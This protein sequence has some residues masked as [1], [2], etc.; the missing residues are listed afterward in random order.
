MTKSLDQL[1]DYLLDEIGAF[2][3][4]GASIPQLLGLVKTFYDGDQ[5]VDNSLLAQVWKW[6][7]RHPDISIGVA[8]KFNQTPLQEF[9]IDPTDPLSSWKSRS[10]KVHA[11]EELIYKSICGHSRQEAQ[12]FPLEHALLM[13]IAAS[14]A[15][16]ILQGDLGRQ[17]G[18]DKRSVPKRT[19]V[20]HTKGYIV[21][22]PVTNKGTKTS[23]LILRRYAHHLA[24]PTI[25]TPQLSVRDVLQRLGDRLLDGARIELTMLVDVLGDEGEA[26]K[27]VLSRIIRT[28][29]KTGCY[30]RVK[31]AFGPS[32]HSSDLKTFV[33]QIHPPSDEDLLSLEQGPIALH[34]SIT[35]LL[36]EERRKT[37]KQGSRAFAQWNPDRLVVN[38]LQD[39]FPSMAPGFEIDAR[40]GLM[41]PFV[42]TAIFPTAPSPSP[43]SRPNSSQTMTS[44]LPA[45]TLPPSPASHPH[46]LTKQ[47]Q[48]VDAT[49]L[50]PRPEEPQIVRGIDGLE[51]IQP[52]MRAKSPDPDPAYTPSRRNKQQKSE[53]KVRTR[54]LDSGEETR[55]Q[56][57]PR[58]FLRGTEKFWQHH[59]WQAK[60]AQVGDQN[61]PVKKLGIMHDPAGMELFESRP[62]DFDETLVQATAAGLPIPSTP[63][64]INPD[65]VRRTRAVLDRV[66]RGAYITPAGMYLGRARHRSQLLIVRSS[67]LNL[68]DWHDRTETPTF[69]FITSMAAHSSS[70][71]R[72]RPR[73]EEL[74]PKIPRSSKNAK[75]KKQETEQPK[76][77]ISPET[78][79]RRGPK[80]QVFFEPVAVAAAV[81]PH[82]PP[83]DRASEDLADYSQY[84]GTTE[85]DT[86]P[87]CPPKQPKT[88]NAS[89]RVLRTRKPAKVALFS[90][91]SM[92]GSELDRSS[93]SAL[94]TKEPTQ[95]TSFTR[96]EA[97]FGQQD[98]QQGH[99]S[100]SEQVASVIHADIQ[101][102]TAETSTA[103]MT[104]ADQ[105][106]TTSM[107]Q[108]QSSSTDTPVLSIANTVLPISFTD[109]AEQ[110]DRIPATLKDGT[111]NA[112]QS[113]NASA[114]YRSSLGLVEVSGVCGSQTVD[115]VN[116][117]RP[118]GRQGEEDPA[119]QMARSHNNFPGQSVTGEHSDMSESEKLILRTRQGR[120]GDGAICQEILFELVQLA[121]GAAPYNR[122]TLQ[123]CMVARWQAKGG[124]GYR[125]LMK[126]IKSAAARLV[127]SEKLSEH[128]FSFRGK[129][130]AIIRRSI[131]HFPNVHA[132][133]AQVT[134][135]K[136]SIM[137]ADTTD[138]VPQE[139]ATEMLPPGQFVDRKSRGREKSTSEQSPGVPRDSYDTTHREN[140]SDEDLVSA[141]SR[142]APKRRKVRHESPPNARQETPHSET[143]PASTPAQGFLTL[144]VP[145]LGT[146]PQVRDYNSRLREPVWKKSMAAASTPDGLLSQTSSHSHGVGRRSRSVCTG[147]GRSIIGTPAQPMLPVNLDDLLRLENGDQSHNDSAE[148][149]F[150]QVDIVAKWEQREAE[151]ILGENVP[152]RFFNHVSSFQAPYHSWVGR[153]FLVHFDEGARPIERE[154]VDFPSWN[155]LKAAQQP[156]AGPYK[157]AAGKSTA[158]GRRVT[159]QS[160]G[161][162][163]K[164]RW[165]VFDDYLE[166]ENAPS[167]S[168]GKKRRRTATATQYLSQDSEWEDEYGFTRERRRPRKKARPMVSSSSSRPSPRLEGKDLVFVLGVVC[169]R[170]L[171]GGI[172]QTINWSLVRRLSPDPDEKAARERWKT[173]VPKH[174][175]EIDNLVQQFQDKYVTAFDQGE[176]PAVDFQNLG[177]TDWRGIVA[178][179]EAN[180]TTSKTPEPRLAASWKELVAEL[181][182]E[183]QRA[184]DFDSVYEHGMAMNNSAKAQLYSAVIGGAS[185]SDML[186]PKAPCGPQLAAARSYVLATVLAPDLTFDAS[187]AEAKLLSLANTGEESKLLLRRAVNSLHREKIIV[188]HAS[189]IL[190]P[191]G[192]RQWKVS[193][194]FEDVM[195][196]RRLVN[197]SL[198][199][200]ATNYKT[201]V[202]DSSFASG[203]TVS[204]SK[205]GIVDD[206]IMLAIL[207][208]ISQ[209]Q[210]TIRP[211][212]DVP[213]SRYGI[214]WENV[215]YQ[216]RLIDRSKVIF[217]TML[218][219]TKT[220]RYGDPVQSSRL[221]HVP[222]GNMDQPGGPIPLWVDIHGNVLAEWWETAVAAVLGLLNL[223]PGLSAEA[224]ERMLNWTLTSND[225]D[226]ILQ[227]SKHSAVARQ[228]PGRKGWEATAW[229]WLALGNG[230]NWT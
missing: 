226:L 180:L 108:H 23:L 182:L 197:R 174:R 203:E 110:A 192:L 123:R 219:P 183:L 191:L 156:Q 76:R 202:L 216:T 114:E 228:A 164:T 96:Q 223:R 74:E 68:V 88:I 218:S 165:T 176:A 145:H 12:L 48:D 210:I 159:R 58:R 39:L 35:D 65:W 43:L 189:D 129:G 152:W 135:L 131:L 207:N 64:A 82:L 167:P 45:N 102:S 100:H 66:D 146:L 22:Q 130:G 11:S 13:Q 7:G 2:G 90:S 44:S 33:Q 86:E 41:G 151:S 31:A 175:E 51:V 138:Y 160:T 157:D 78:A 17:T 154:Y 217:T 103:N 153:W 193:N 194:I 55:P 150:Q 204:M 101:Y 222:R 119:V 169:I 95:Q 70:C 5:C 106:V 127:E 196:S 83:E 56:G 118:D 128:T 190:E 198:L 211:G 173:L 124:K 200:I 61:V 112:T 133:S 85:T 158:Q 122:T 84:M 97:S 181:D 53:K 47:I 75:R 111:P 37:L 121:R 109:R 224:C 170:N 54:I 140:C 36:N 59:F 206:G 188:R 132:T 57:R 171:V 62:H 166:V 14:R 195:E 225:I 125:P 10:P 89:K 73:V 107:G 98:K 139:W 93:S 38:Q 99:V 161:A 26:A 178:W 29:E 18:Q 230:V 134:E 205:E 187:S 69:R 209:G 9:Q 15:N 71:T 137:V 179:A 24:A 30:K 155:G 185:A 215:G 6:L 143:M 136:E 220:Y 141:R 115:E 148:S 42:Q 46:L 116:E 63:D 120:G 28:L 40:K 199:R 52:I 117:E 81:S 201:Q 8:R 229:W 126:M 79:A 227:W 3:P 92:P 19:D 60:L 21:K 67:R 80:L 87:E 163:K 184:R 177:Q 172:E 221:E 214:D 20:L 186:W 4:P 168:R 1:I 147:N 91:N 34:R 25:T 72:Y 213:H 113:R 104:G 162:I 49:N 142:R 16:G 144:K 32:A 208:L 212:P 77:E 105:L 27:K 50:I 94:I 149:F